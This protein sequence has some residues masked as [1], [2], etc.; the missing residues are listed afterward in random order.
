MS[1]IKFVSRL[2]SSTLLAI[3]LQGCQLGIPEDLKNADETLE[4]VSQKLD[5]CLAGLEA[6]T[7]LLKQCIEEKNNEGDD[8]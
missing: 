8:R 1:S 3:Y 2:V 5:Q 7:L 4:E 6:A